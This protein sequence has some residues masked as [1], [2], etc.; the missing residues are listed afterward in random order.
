MKATSDVIELN[1]V[2]LAVGPKGELPEFAAK[3]GRGAAAL[4]LQPLTFAFT[5]F[6]SPAGPVPACA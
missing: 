2:P 6:P 4:V 5:S 3:T 1:G